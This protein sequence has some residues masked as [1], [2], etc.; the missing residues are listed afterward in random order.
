MKYKTLNK[1]TC[2]ASSADPCQLRANYLKSSPTAMIIFCGFQYFLIYL[3]KYFWS[4]LNSP[5]LIFQLLLCKSNVSKKT[6]EAL[7]VYFSNKLQFER[8]LYYYRPGLTTRETKMRVVGMRSFIF[9]LKQRKPLVLRL[10]E[11]TAERFWFLDHIYPKREFCIFKLFLAPNFSLNWKFWFFG[12]HL[13]QKGISNRKQKS[14]HHYW[15]LY[16]WISLST[17]FQVKLTVLIFWTKFALK[18]HCKVWDNFWH[19]KAL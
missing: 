7:N 18:A 2:R 4:L 16:I 8:K 9:W 13:T 19:L 10:C 5:N 6:W 12:P 14:E 11:S 15:I 17:K 1:T 3:A